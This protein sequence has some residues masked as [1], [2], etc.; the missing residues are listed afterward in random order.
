MVDNKKDEADKGEIKSKDATEWGG[1]HTI[2]R[3]N[4]GNGPR[5]VDDEADKVQ[6]GRNPR[7][8]KKD[9]DEAHENAQ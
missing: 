6:F 5:K 8:A 1:D 7:K 3:K 4:G 9:G 2:S